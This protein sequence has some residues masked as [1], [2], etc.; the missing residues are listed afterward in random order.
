MKLKKKFNLI[1][2]HQ[3]TD[4]E[5]YYTDGDVKVITASNELKGYWNKAIV[6]EEDLPCITYPTKGNDGVA[7]VQYKIFDAN[8][9][10]VLI[11]FPEWREK[12]NLEWL[13]FKLGAV[14]LKIQTSKSG[15]SYLNKEIV[16]DYDF[17][18]PNTEIQL[19]ELKYYK[20]L[21]FLRGN[22]EYILS[23]TKKTY[24]QAIVINSE[25]LGETKVTEIMNYISRNDCLSE[26]GIY[27]LSVN[28][29]DSNNNISVIS[30]K[31]HD[32][33][34]YVPY[35]EKLHSLSNKPC[36]QIVT[37]G[38]NA[39]TI[40][41]LPVGIYATN[42]NAMLLVLKDSIK[43]NIGIDGID[44]EIVYL[45][46]LKLYLQPLFY[47]YRTSSEHSVFPLTEAVGD[48][49]TPLFKYN[50]K[51]DE[52]VKKYDTLNFYCSFLKEELNR[53]DDLFSKQTVE[54]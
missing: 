50:K 25:S 18:M 10:A 28:L 44:Q 17:E 38:V 16:E 49:T 29:T 54:Y 52:L 35:D 2:G 27:N 37:R 31:I 40:S 23:Q 36:L 24:Q 41:Y 15:V 22:I 19:I 7:Y 32:V 30:G 48:I 33:Y 13:S 34:G 4:E 43:S 26:E 39:G 6:K 21:Q 1:Q 42:T 12:I 9:T 46:F 51:M 11:P 8:N 3:I 20:K 14:F 45:K 47:D 53:I 5:L